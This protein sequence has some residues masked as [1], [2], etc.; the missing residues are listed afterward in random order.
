MSGQFRNAISSV[1][2]CSGGR[3]HHTVERWLKCWLVEGAMQ[4]SHL[5]SSADLQCSGFYL[6]H[7]E[8]GPFSST[9]LHLKHSFHS[10]LPHQLT[11]GGREVCSFGSLVQENR[12][13]T[14]VLS[15]SLNTLS[16]S[17]SRQGK[18]LSQR[19]EQTPH[20]SADRVDSSTQGPGTSVQ[21]EA[22]AND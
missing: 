4:R 9:H 21:G 3:L 22:R 20:G 15:E 12:G 8:I 11:E 13:S 14:F 10:C 16:A 7:R 17:H 18:H 2:P 19:T 1:Q 5:P 6:Q